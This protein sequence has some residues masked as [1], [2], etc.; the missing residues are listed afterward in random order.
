MTALC[1]P[2]QSDRL[3]ASKVVTTL[4]ATMLVFIVLHVTCAWQD[5]F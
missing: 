5:L 1:W 3:H 2:L 4:H